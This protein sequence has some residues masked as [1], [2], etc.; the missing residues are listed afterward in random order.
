MPPILRYLLLDVVLAVLVTLA[1]EIGL[2]YLQLPGVLLV[3]LF[4]DLP[5]PYPQAVSN[6]PH[7]VAVL[8]AT[9]L[10]WLALFGAWATI[11]GMRE[12][13][14]NALRRGPGPTR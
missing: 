9:L 10:F 11:A 12:Q 5:D 14:V 13:Q 3:R 7:S 8:T 4:V 6:A 2:R 1:A